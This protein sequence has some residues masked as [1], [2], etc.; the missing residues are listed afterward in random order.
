[1]D[2]NKKAY[3]NLVKTF[4]DQYRIK[5]WEEIKVLTSCQLL[6]ILRFFM[7][8]DK[9]GDGLITID[10]LEEVLGNNCLKFKTSSAEIREIIKDV[11]NNPEFNFATERINFPTFAEIVDKLKR[12]K[13][14]MAYLLNRLN[15]VIFILFILLLVMYVTTFY[16]Y[17]T[18]F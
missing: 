3:H 15:Y 6:C 9:K 16:S 17:K 10:E 18:G 2:Y 1:M 14:I 12:E 5:N 13:L 4:P 8:N 11:T 7:K